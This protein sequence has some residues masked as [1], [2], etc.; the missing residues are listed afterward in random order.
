M[1][2]HSQCRVNGDPQGEETSPR[3]ILTGAL[4]ASPDPAVIST[5]LNLTLHTEPVRPQ[6]VIY[7]F[8]GVGANPKGRSMGWQFVKDNW[9]TFHT[10]YFRSSFSLLARIISSST[11]SFSSLKDMQDVE[12]FFSGRDQTSIDRTVRQSV[13]RIRL[14]ASWLERNRDPVAKWLHQFVRIGRIAAA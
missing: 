4:G 9:S 5:A 8:S 7:I 10:R 6:D 13:E 12:D 1:K 14:Q 3:R 2:R 11:S